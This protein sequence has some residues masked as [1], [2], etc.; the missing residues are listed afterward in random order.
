MSSES[1]SSKQSPNDVPSEL[2]VAL[3]AGI[4]QTAR[5]TLLGRLLNGFDLQDIFSA[6]HH[7]P[8]FIETRSEYIATRV[9]FMAFFYAIAVPLWTPIDYFLLSH[10]HFRLIVWPKLILTLV[11]L[12]LGQQAVRGLSCKHLHIVFMLTVLT[13]CLFHF[14]SMLILN[15]GTPEPILAGYNYMPFMVVS[16]L[17]VFPLTINWS[18]TLISL[19]LCC[20]LSL[21]AVLGRL[22]G[23][24]T[25]NTLWTFCIL[26]GIALWV[27]SSQL[28]VLLKLYRESSRDPLTGIINRRIM[29]KCLASKIKHANEGGSPFC[30]LLFDLDRFK[31]INDNYGH[32][33]GDKVL[34]AAAEVLQQGLR[35][36]D[37]VARFGGEEFLAVLPQC[38]YP[39]AIA[40]AEGMRGDLNRT[41]VLTAD[42][43]EIRLSTS[44]GITEYEIGEEI[45]TTLNRADEA[46]Y[47]AKETGRNRAV[48][49]QSEHFSRL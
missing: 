21:Q 46:L 45:S 39:D 40:L 44:I 14:A 32:L 17:G 41:T 18:L 12:P 6:E 36:Q 16:M 27:Q 31:R 8:D 24:D 38:R 25:V 43:E 11:L 35:E 30:I 26:A 20:Y 19:I 49:R 3:R 22:I 7:T 37:V 10:E 5:K 23:M 1:H 4:K 15:S 13:A 29:M 28:L 2:D 33:V 47:Q 48:H 34:K 42:G 9:R